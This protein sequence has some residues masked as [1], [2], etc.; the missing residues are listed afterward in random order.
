MQL[1]GSFPPVWRRI[2]VA[3]DLGGDD[4]HDV[5]QVVFGWPDSPRRL[6]LLREPE[7]RLVPTVRGRGLAEDL[8]R[9]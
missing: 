2:E 3:S 6:T 1:E 8:I 7:G 4:V 9:L 5:L